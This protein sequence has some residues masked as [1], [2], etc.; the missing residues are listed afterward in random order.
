MLCKTASNLF[1]K[2]SV[3]IPVELINKNQVKMIKNNADLKMTKTD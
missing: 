1:I 3:K 2:S